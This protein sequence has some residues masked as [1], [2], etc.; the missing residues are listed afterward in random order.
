MNKKGGNK[1][2]SGFGLLKGHS[3]LHETWRKLHEEDW[4]H[5]QK[6]MDEMNEDITH[7]EFHKRLK[8]VLGIKARARSHA[9]RVKGKKH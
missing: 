1:N 8:R 7:R 4:K 2:K 6:E 5:E 9:R 3:G